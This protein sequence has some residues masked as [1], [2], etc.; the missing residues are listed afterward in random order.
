MRQEA[1]RNLLDTD[2]LYVIGDPHSNNTRNL[3]RIAPKSV[4]KVRL[5]E[6]VEDIDENELNENM[7]VA[8]T[9]GASTPTALTDQVI[10][11]LENLW[12]EK[13]SRVTQDI[14]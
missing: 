8:V 11:Y 14:L 12:P 2:L 13:P 10:D 6:S 1:I 5:I 9:A 7:Y 4:K 3:A